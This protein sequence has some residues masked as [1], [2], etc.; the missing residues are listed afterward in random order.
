MATVNEFA[1]DTS[2][3]QDLSVTEGKLRPITLEM[4]ECIHNFDGDKDR[5]WDLIALATGP[6]CQKG[7]DILGEV[8]GLKYWFMQLSTIRGN[9]GKPQQVV[10]TVLFN[11]ADQPY[12]FFSRGVEESLRLMISV[13]GDK[14]FNPPKPIVVAESHDSGGKR[15]YAITPAPRQYE[16]EE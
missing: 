10:R 12:Y 9:Q 14:V 4:P 16:T 2:E 8:F 3:E 1:V 15:F 6:K 7:R 5:K 11:G 13:C